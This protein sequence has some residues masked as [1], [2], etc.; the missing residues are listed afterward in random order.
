MTAPRRHPPRITSAATDPFRP[1]AWVEQAA[2]QHHHPDLWFPPPGIRH[3]R[4]GQPNHHPD[5]PCPICV[6]AACPVITDCLRHA[7]AHDERFGI[8]G[9][10][11][12]HQRVALLRQRSTPSR[13]EV[14][15]TDAGAHRHYRLGERCCEVCRQARTVA[16]RTR[17]ANVRQQLSLSEGK[18]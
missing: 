17:R 5:M 1:Q 2:C 16:A 13:A 6:C 4:R 7:L 9:G 10:H 11:T 12:E 3:H 18:P 14:C 8:W 15:G